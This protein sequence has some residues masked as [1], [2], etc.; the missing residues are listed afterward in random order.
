MRVGYLTG[1]R[2]YLRPLE[3]ADQE[4]ATAWFNSPFPINATRAKAFLEEEQE[5]WYSDRFMALI[6]ARIEDDHPIG[7]MTYRTHD[8]RVA[9]VRFHMAPS[10]NDAD[11][12][13]ADAIRMVVP[14]LRDEHELMVVRLGLASDQ[15]ESIR[16]AEDLSMRPSVRLREWVARDGKRVDEIVYEALNRRWEVQDA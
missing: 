14:W 16:A 15:F 7:G 10:L 12:M 11:E 5:D 6:V 9:T 13:R 3:E 4:T 2:I 8:R 1:K